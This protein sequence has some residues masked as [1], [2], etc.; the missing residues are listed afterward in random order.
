MT[1]LV[2]I[3]VTIAHSWLEW[4]AGV[5]LVSE[6]IEL[7]FVVF[8]NSKNGTY[9]SGARYGRGGSCFEKEIRCYDL[10]SIFEVRLLEAA[11]YATE[12]FLTS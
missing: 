5:I 9:A 4:Y 3:T 7:Y 11:L 8:W 12:W 1:V 2:E 6:E 10:W